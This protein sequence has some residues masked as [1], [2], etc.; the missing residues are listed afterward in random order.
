MIILGIC[1]RVQKRIGNIQGNLSY[2]CKEGVERG[3]RSGNDRNKKKRN[4]FIFLASLLII[5]YLADKISVNIP[6]R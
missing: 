1:K 4:K 2:P 3:L 5:S 6:P